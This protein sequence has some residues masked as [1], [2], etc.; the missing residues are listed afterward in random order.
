MEKRQINPWTWQE[1]FGFAQA[2]RVDS[3]QSVVFVAGQAPISADGEVVAPGDFEAQARRVF[4]NLRTVLEQAGA[5]FESVVK[6]TIYVTD[7]SSRRDRGAVGQSVELDPL[8]PSTGRPSAVTP[9]VSLWPRG[10]LDPHRP[11]SGDGF[12]WLPARRATQDARLRAPDAGPVGKAVSGD[13]VE[14]R[15]CERCG[16]ASARGC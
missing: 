2:W 5:S 14:S 11:R 16:C 1:R 8:R 15:R 6:I 12:S 10:S 3:A 4:E 13:G 7:M 9:P